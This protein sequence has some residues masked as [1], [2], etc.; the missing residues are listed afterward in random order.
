MKSTGIT[1]HIDKLGRFKI[2]KELRTSLNIESQDSLCLVLHTKK[3][4]VCYKIEDTCIF[5]RNRKNIHV[6]KNKNICIK[7]LNDIRKLQKS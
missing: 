6:F 2:P 5:C 7:C 4:I 1:K 3:K